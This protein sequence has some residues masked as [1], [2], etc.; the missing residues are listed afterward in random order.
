MTERRNPAISLC[1]IVRDE[2]QHLARCLTSVKD[3]IDEIIV[4]DTGSSDSTP[5]LAQK[6][7]ATV[8]FAT[9][10]NDFSKAR[11]QSIQLARGEW[12]L[13][14]D[15]DEE[16][17]TETGQALRKLADNPDVEAYTFTII[18]YTASNEY[19]PELTGSNVRMFRNSPDYHFEGA[20]HEQIKPSILRT[21]PRAVISYSGF[22][23]F[24]YGYSSDNM[25][26]KYKTLRNI[27]ILEGILEQNPTDGFSHYNLGVSY[28][29]NGEL[30]QARIHLHLAK[31]HTPPTAGYLPALYRNYA[32]C[33]ND[34][35]EY[36]PAL[37]L[38]RE[39]LSHFPDYPDLYY[40]EGQI[41][42]SLQLFEEAKQC[43]SQCLHF[44]KVNPDYIS[45]KGI[46]SFLANEQLA[47]I[48]CTLQDW[49]R[50]LHHQIQALKSG[51][52][53]FR[54]ALRAALIA[55]QHFSSKDEVRA[56]LG[57]NLS[58]FNLDELL[59]TAFCSNLDPSNE[60]AGQ[61][62]NAIL[63]EPKSAED[64]CLLLDTLANM[65][66]QS[67]RDISYT[68]PYFGIAR[69]HLLSLATFRAKLSGKE[70]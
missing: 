44:V 52:Q 66:Q 67:L 36:E 23:I 9:W 35:G 63:A 47:D 58:G 40:L 61:I 26:K 24:H 37:S 8:H 57:G 15:A 64:Y 5:L 55:R 68:Y 14:L 65:F 30:E 69:H 32:I 10:E 51:A 29:V 20:V 46:N 21:N 17:P 42:T 56:F 33:L 48:Y 59:E 28:Y 43:F 41:Y 45:M 39:G 13:L 2:E 16:I 49:P 70:E 27:R 25:K 22:S 18:N 34:L 50:A 54:S 31:Q 60:G 4:L 6:L 38:I 3:Y 1:M 11:N 62:R 53:S 19:S 7:G 12:I